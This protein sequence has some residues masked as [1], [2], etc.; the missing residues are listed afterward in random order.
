VLSLG[1]QLG[2]ERGNEGVAGALH[3]P[4]ALDVVLGVLVDPVSEQ[5]VALLGV[6]HL[7]G[8]KHPGAR[9]VE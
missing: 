7:E 3:G 5:L 6:V 9:G 4:S 2:Y 8:A 1:Q